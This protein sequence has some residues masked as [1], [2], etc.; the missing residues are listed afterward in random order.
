M[1][2]HI[3]IGSNDID[4]SQR[5][6]DAVLAVFGA[7][8]ATRNQAPTGHMRLFYQAGGNMFCVS[9]PINGEPATAAN[10]VQ[11]ALIGPVLKLV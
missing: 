7:K 8:P 1:F 10:G 11:P 9:E 2:S 6:Y 4:R 5:F 3:M